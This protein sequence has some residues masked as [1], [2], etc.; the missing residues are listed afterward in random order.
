L[1]GVLKELQEFYDIDN[2]S[3]GLMQAAFIT[4]YMFLSLVF[5]Y[6]GDRFNRV[7]IIT[8]GIFCW[9]AATLASSF[10]DQGVSL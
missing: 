1:L 3:T 6:L 7:L 8:F 5:G 9:S 4:S 10:V 2:A